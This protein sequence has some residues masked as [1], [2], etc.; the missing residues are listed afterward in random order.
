MIKNLEALCNINAP[1]GAENAVRDY[2]LSEISSHAQCKT[3]ASGNIIAFKKGEKTP[4]HRI[5]IDAHMD[6]VGFIVSA[7]TAEGFLK[8]H[9]VGGI[10][11]NILFGKKVLIN[12]NIS[13]VIGCKPIHLT[14]D[15]EG[16]KCPKAENMYIDIGAT[17]R[18]E[19]ENMVALGDFGVV[20]GTYE[21]LGDNILAK[22]IDDRAGCAILIELIKTYNEYDFYATFTVGEEI[23]T[24]G[25]KTATFGVEPEYALVLEATTA[26]DIYGSDESNRVCALGDGPAISFMDNGTLYNRKLFN[27]AFDCGIK[28]QAKTAVAGGNNSAAIHLSGSGVKTLAISVP[29][30]YIHSPSCISNISDIKNTFALAKALMSKI[31][32]GE[33]E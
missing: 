4:K 29:C 33:I 23:G 20:C 10:N 15:D 14:S 2:I 13:G 25:A 31:C 32:S 12:N 18:E 26:A 24:R 8:F 6:E 9:T 30:R 19:A 17:S 11:D 22:A 27:A 5:M 7:I 28:C 3:D 1:S 16:E 21:V